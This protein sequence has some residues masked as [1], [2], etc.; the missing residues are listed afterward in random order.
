MVMDTIGGPLWSALDPSKV[1]FSTS[2]SATFRMA[3][4]SRRSQS[5][6]TLVSSRSTTDRGGKT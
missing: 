5:D 4:G 3:A 2:L 1:D 6:F